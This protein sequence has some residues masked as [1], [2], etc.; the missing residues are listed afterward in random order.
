MEKQTK[1][2]VIFGTGAVAAE[3]TSYLED[4]DWGVNEGIEIKGYIA[5]SDDAQISWKKYNFNKP[6]LG[7]INNYHVDKNDYF[8]LAVAG[9]ELKK[10]CV[11][12]IESKGGKFITLI[13]PTAMVAR[14]A[15]IGKGN[16]ISPYSMIGPNVKLG[17]FNLLTSQSIV[18]H[19]S[20]V[21]SYNFFATALLCG[22]TIV[23][24]YNY[25]GI[26]ATTI[27]DINI[28]NNN[29]IQAGMI[30]DKNVLN[31]STVFYRYKEKLIVLPKEQ[32][33]N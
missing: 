27:P 7:D 21:G 1:Q 25:F 20:I 6:F 30:V 11:E 12:I 32:N 24:D 14:T 28:G 18:S 2:I 19:D 13:H 17:N 29:V 31:D 33:N 16:I 26:K 4:G 9:G 15:T 22:N 23:G 8:I 10:K 3:L 5:S